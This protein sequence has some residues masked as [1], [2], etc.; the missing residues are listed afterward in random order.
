M[1]TFSLIR[2]GETDWNLR[3]LV[4]GST[5][6]PLNQTGLRQAAEAVDRIKA[7]DVDI[8]WSG[9]V[10]STLSRARV[11]ARIIAEGLE[12]PLMDP[13]ADLVERNFGSKEGSDVDEIHRLHPRWDFPEAEPN[14]LVFER[15]YNALENLRKQDESRSLIVVAHGG[16]F[17]DMLSRISGYRIG[18]IA[19]TAVNMIEHVDGDWVVRMVNG[20]PFDASLFEVLTEAH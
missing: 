10:S 1:T 14:H 2:H 18:S 3:N 9:V 7:L 19:N 20:E 17:R 13:I 4:Q 16:V 8:D 6:I 15:A 11:T 5:D 12:L